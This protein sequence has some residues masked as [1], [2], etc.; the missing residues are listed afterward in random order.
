MGTGNYRI[1]TA[2]VLTSTADRFIRWVKLDAIGPARYAELEQLGNAII[3][4]F[5]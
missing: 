2:D 5:K 3:G 1:I 4:V